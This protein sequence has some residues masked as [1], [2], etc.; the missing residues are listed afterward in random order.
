M[1]FWTD[2]MPSIIRYAFY[3]SHQ[4]E[5]LPARKAPPPPSVPSIPISVGSPRVGGLPSG[6][7]GQYRLHQS[8]VLAALGRVRIQQ[9]TALRNQAERSLAP[10]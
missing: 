3:A 8:P 4:F 10:T 7:K 2:L 9:G 6:G 5:F 1:K